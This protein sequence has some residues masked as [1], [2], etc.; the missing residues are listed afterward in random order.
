MP[1]LGLIIL[2]AIIQLLYGWQKLFKNKI[3]NRNV[4]KIKFS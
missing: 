3:L 2:P 1:P 4:S